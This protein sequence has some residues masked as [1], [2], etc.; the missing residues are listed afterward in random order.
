M[1]N[2]RTRIYSGNIASADLNVGKLLDNEKKFGTADFNLELKGFNYKNHYPESYIKGNIASFEYSQYK[3]EN[4]ALDG[5]YKD[6]GFN[7]KLAMDDDNGSVQINGNFN[8]GVRHTRIQ[9]EGRL[10]ESPT[11]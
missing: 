6:G 9:L 10:K 8:G 4:I 11:G 5:V 7:G 3:Y 2:N 1:T